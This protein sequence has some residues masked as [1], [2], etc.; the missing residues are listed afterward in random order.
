MQLKHPLKKLLFILQW[1]LATHYT[2][3]DTAMFILIRSTQFVERS[4]H[5]SSSGSSTFMMNTNLSAVTLLTNIADLRQY[6]GGII[7]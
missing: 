2:G 4:Y 3:R 1:H 6:K 5:L 7:S